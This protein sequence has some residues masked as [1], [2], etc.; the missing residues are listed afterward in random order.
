MRRA[1]GYVQSGKIDLLVA[2]SSVWELPASE[3][4]LWLPTFELGKRVAEQ[5]KLRWP[6]E[7]KGGSDFTTFLAGYDP[8]LMKTETPFRE[9]P[10]VGKNKLG[11]CRRIAIVSP[12]VTTTRTISDSLVISRGLVQSKGVGWS[13]IFANGDVLCDDDLTNAVV[14]SGGDIRLKRLN[15]DSVLIARG[16]ITAPVALGCTLLAGGTITFT[17]K[18]W[19]PQDPNLQNIV[20]EGESKPLG[21]ITFFELSQIGLEATD[22]DKAVRVAKFTDASPLRKAGVAVGDVVM[23]VNGTPVATAEEL[24]RALRDATATKGE[25]TLNVGRDG[26]ATDIRVPLPD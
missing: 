11:A 13:V 18:K 3:E 15:K 2:N 9:P 23:K 5:G 20:K 24:R 1:E 10:A 16:N 19:T 4:R 12:E 6:L 14:I 21:F 22:K 26:K 17:E 7:H 8:T 25:A